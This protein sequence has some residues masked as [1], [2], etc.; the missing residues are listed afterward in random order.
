MADLGRILDM[1]E[2]DGALDLSPSGFAPRPDWPTIDEGD[3]LREVDYRGLFPGARPTRRGERDYEVFGDDWEVGQELIDALFEETSGEPAASGP[4]A[5]D[6]WAWYQPIHYFGLDW[7]IFIKETG[8]VECARRIAR[9]YSGAPPPAASAGLWAKAVLRAAFNVLFL[10]EH[11]HHKTESLALRLHVVEQRPV[12]PKYFDQVYRVTAGTKDQIEEGLAN[13]DSYRRLGESTYWTG[14]TIT[15]LTRQYLKRSFQTAPP[16][17]ANAKDLLGK[18]D[19]QEEQNLFFAQVQETTVGA[20]R[21]NLSEFSIATH[22][23][24]SLFSVDQRIWTIIPAG[25]SSVLPTHPGGPILPTSGV[26]D[27]LTRRGWREVSAGLYETGR[28]FRNRR[29][30]MIILPFKVHV[31]GPVVKAVADT[32]GLKMAELERL[33]LR[34]RQW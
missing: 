4:P 23:N 31:S 9:T 26:A 11:Y 14:R 32:A 25:G 15:A 21:P 12:Y 30:Q 27:L 3:E 22:L 6:V 1:L 5:W 24:H 16:G 29:G 10:H 18:Q 33:T 19:F 7:G 28:A 8:L 34:G 2:R 17:Y 20:V 13:A